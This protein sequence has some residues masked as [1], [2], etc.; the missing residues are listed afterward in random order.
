MAS[1]EKWI[2]PKIKEG[3]ITYLK[4]EEF[5]NIKYITEGAFG[6]ID[7]AH[8]NNG[9]IIVALKSLK[10][11]STKSDIEEQT[12]LKELRILRKVSSHPNVN[13]FFGITKALDEI[14]CAYLNDHKLGLKSFNDTLEKYES[15]SHDIFDHLFNNKSIKHY[16]VM[17]GVFYGRGFGTEKDEAKCK[18]WIT[19][20]SENNDIN[21]H[22]E[23]AGCYYFFKEKYEEAVKYY[24]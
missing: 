7:R 24:Q 10:S 16:E 3:D 8:W 22:H 18:D 19:K 11:I 2:D 4:Y 12:F 17:V 15:Q 1:I 9:D 14:I 20:A 21:G 6:K 13:R 23:L 5:S